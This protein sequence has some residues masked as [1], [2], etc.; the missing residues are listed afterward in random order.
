[1]VEVVVVTVIIGIMAV[2]AVPRYTSVI[3]RQRAEAAAKR[4]EADLAYAQRQARLLS[5]PIQVEFDISNDCYQSGDFP[6]SDYL[7][8]DFKVVLSQE[9]YRAAIISANFGGLT[10]ITFNGYG[11][12]DN[13]GTVVIQVGTYQKT[14]TVDAGGG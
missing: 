1:M 10:D 6:D 12:P 5:N 7:D 11:L 9:P 13:G 14:I 4:I 8:E 2:V 3:T